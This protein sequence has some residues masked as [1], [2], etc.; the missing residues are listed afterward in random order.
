MLN[1]EAADGEES[2]DEDVEMTESNNKKSL[3]AEYL[4]YLLERRICTYQQQLTQPVEDWSKFAVHPR[5]QA[6]QANYFDI[7]KQKIRY[8]SFNEVFTPFK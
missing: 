8:Q 2:N 6:M 1:Y 3:A 7:V 5:L 4:E